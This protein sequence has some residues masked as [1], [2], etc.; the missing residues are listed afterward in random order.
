MQP[1]NIKLQNMAD[2]NHFLNCLA[3]YLTLTLTFQILI[4]SKASFFT[5]INNEKLFFSRTDSGQL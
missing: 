1:E 4:T 3:V 2:D 5:K